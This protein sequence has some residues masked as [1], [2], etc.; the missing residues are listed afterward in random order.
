MPNEDSN[1]L[2]IRQADHKDV[3]D[4][5]SDA[6]ATWAFIIDKIE[7]TDIKAQLDSVFRSL[8]KYTIIMEQDLNWANMIMEVILSSDNL[9]PGTRTQAQGFVDI[10]DKKYV[11]MEMRDVA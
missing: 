3:V 5:V 4:K 6:F 9:H 7:D 1:K 2:V 10:H 11:P 8:V